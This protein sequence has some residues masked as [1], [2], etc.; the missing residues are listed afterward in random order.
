[1]PS[2]SKIK[3][4][5]YEREVAKSLSET[6][7]EPFVRVPN[8]GA[9]VGGINNH[10]KNFLDSNQTKSFKGATGEGAYTGNTVGSSVSLH[11]QTSGSSYKQLAGV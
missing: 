11:R 10:R 6:Y 4:S 5:G 3:G 2:K 8:S 1:M 9:Y 7:N